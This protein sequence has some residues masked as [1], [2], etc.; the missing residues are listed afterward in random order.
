MHGPPVNAYNISPGACLVSEFILSFLR[1]EKACTW[2]PKCANETDQGWTK[3]QWVRRILTWCTAKQAVLCWINCQRLIR[4]K[5]PGCVKQIT[6]HIDHGSQLPFRMAIHLFQASCRRIIPYPP[7]F[8]VIRKCTIHIYCIKVNVTERFIE[9]TQNFELLKVIDS[10]IRFHEDYTLGPDSAHAHKTENIHDQA[11]WWPTIYRSTS[12]PTTT[13]Q[14][15]WK[16]I[17]CIT[18]AQQH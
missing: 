11:S 17:I 5:Q 8:V 1:G 15:H 14:W 13:Y 12:I 9:W 6:S 2:D 7:M 3:Q 16:H 10:V 4:F 18:D